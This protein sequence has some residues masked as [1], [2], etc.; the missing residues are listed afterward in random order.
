MYECPARGGLKGTKAIEDWED[1]QDDGTQEDAGDDDGYDDGQAVLRK[2]G[3]EDEEADEEENECNLEEGRD[4]CDERG[5][6][7]AL[8]R[9]KA[10]LAD[11]NVLA[12]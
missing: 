5:D 7:P 9:L 6:L 3:D 10:N 2:R 11:E 4:G 1:R 12:R 8:P